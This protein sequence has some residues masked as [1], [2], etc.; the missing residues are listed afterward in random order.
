MEDQ[1]TFLG[2]LELVNGNLCCRTICG[3]FP[4]AKGLVGSE[5]IREYVGAEA[6]VQVKNGIVVECHLDSDGGFRYI[7]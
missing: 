2:T 6:E 4:F 5:K 7:S 1:E 3:T